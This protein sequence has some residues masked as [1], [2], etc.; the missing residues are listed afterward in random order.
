MQGA[1]RQCRRRFFDNLIH[2]GIGNIVYGLA[3]PSRGGQ[4]TLGCGYLQGGVGQCD[5]ALRGLRA[6]QQCQVVNIV[7]LMS[8]RQLGV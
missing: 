4:L 1:A 8:E 3:V 2:I 7:G 6:R 5:D